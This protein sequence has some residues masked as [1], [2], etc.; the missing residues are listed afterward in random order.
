MDYRAAYF[1]AKNFFNLVDILAKG[2]IM[3]KVVKV[4]SYHQILYSGGVFGQVK[5]GNLL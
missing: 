4:Q 2:I 3:F 1:A 5:L